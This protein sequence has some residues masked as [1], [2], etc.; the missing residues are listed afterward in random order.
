MKKQVKVTG[1]YGLGQMVHVVH[2]SDDA[3]AAP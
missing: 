2:M 1:D 3:E